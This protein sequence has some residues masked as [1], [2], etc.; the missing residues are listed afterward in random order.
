MPDGGDFLCEPPGGGAARSLSPTTG[1]LLLYPS[2]LRHAVA[3]VTRGQRH[4]LA[5]WLTRDGG[6]D[7]DAALLGPGRPFCARGALTPKS[8]C[9]SAAPLE[10]IPDA[11]FCDAQRGGADA[12][13]L[14]LAARGLRPAADDGVAPLVLARSADGTR[15]P[16]AFADATHALRAAAYAEWARGKPLAAMDDDAAAEAA[17]AADAHERAGRSIVAALLPRWRASNALFG[18]D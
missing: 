3:P 1:T 13:M 15:L 8:L 14:Q 10:D 16:V 2:T 12:R 11:F 4:T 9:A 18:A 5:I 17:A 6:H 7:E